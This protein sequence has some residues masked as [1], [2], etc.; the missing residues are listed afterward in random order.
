MIAKNFH[1]YA[2]L[3]FLMLFWT[4]LAC[5][6]VAPL[7][8]ALTPTPTP[9]VE[10]DPRFDEPPVPGRPPFEPAEAPAAA[11]TREPDPPR[12]LEYGFG[13]DGKDVAYAFVVENPNPDI[14]LERAG[15]ELTAFDSQGE[16]ARS[17]SGTIRFLAPGERLGAA[18]RFNVDEGVV[19]ERLVIE[20]TPGRA[21][22]AAEPVSFSASDLAYYPGDIASIVTGIIHAGHAEN[23]TDVRLSAILYGEDGQIIGG[24]YAFVN[25]IPANDSTGVRVIVVSQ[26]EVGEVALYPALSALSRRSA[27]MDAAEGEDLLVWDQ[28]FGQRRRQVGYGFLVENTHVTHAV[29]E[30]R[31]R[32]VFFNEA[33][34]VI[35]VDDGSIELLLPGQRAGLAGRVFLPEGEQA[36]TMRVQLYHGERREMD[37]VEETR[38][39]QASFTR[40]IR[41]AD[42]TLTAD[43]FSQ[44]ATGALAN[45]YDRAV[46][47][48]RVSAIVYDEAGAIVGGGYRF[49]DLPA[50]QTMEAELMITASETAVR[51]ELYALP[52]SLTAFE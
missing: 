27:G 49:L 4:T 29:A 42:G 48:L 13:Q 43:T 47:W 14:A 7:L 40:P 11:P 26:G 19:I 28:G 6:S 34:V 33:G 45:P 39:F 30:S 2:L 51:A 31:H 18:N 21:A 52:T 46:T 37:E 16:I 35:G 24:G 36:A 5:E 32:T 23:V 22:P 12:L 10:S 9:F 20:I 1:R 15:Y 25:F 41:P 8:E 3:F 17:S 44:W 50:G 38:P